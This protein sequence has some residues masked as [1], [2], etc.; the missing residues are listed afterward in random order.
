[1]GKTGD[2][3]EKK[4]KT[5]YNDPSTYAVKTQLMKNHFNE[6]T[7]GDAVLIVNNKKNNTDGYIGGN[8]LME[9]AIAFQYKKP[10]YILNPISE[11]LPIKEEIYGVFPTFLNGDLKKISL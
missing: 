5:W 7:K 9:I 2:F 1:M 3:D 11:E 10:L 6:I 8:T 4:Q